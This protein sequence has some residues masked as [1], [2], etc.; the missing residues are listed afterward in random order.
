MGRTGT[1]EA[2]NVAEPDREGRELA[3]AGPANVA[4]R[5][6]V[7]G[8]DVTDHVRVGAVKVLC[9]ARY[10]VCACHR[11]IGHDGAHLCTC[12]GSWDD[13]GRIFSLPN[14]DLGIVGP[15]W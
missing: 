9:G 11:E 4:A 8:E 2:R 7:D 3:L 14:L 6:L 13:E 5:I 10:V 1:G 15:A 12:E